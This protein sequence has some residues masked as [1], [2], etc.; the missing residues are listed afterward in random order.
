M[1]P[2]IYSDEQR[3]IFVYFQKFSPPF[4]LHIMEAC[5]E[6]GGFQHFGG[7]EFALT[8]PPTE[9]GLQ[10]ETRKLLVSKFYCKDILQIHKHIFL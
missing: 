9:S 2:I 3:Q 6:G 5:F 10:T 1:K 4:I 8:P 7:F